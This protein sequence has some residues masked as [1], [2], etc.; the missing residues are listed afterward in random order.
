MNMDQRRSLFLAALLF[1]SPAYAAE[2]GPAPAE[3]DVLELNTGDHRNWIQLATAMPDP[4]YGSAEARSIAETVL[5]YQT[6]N[7][8]WAKNTGYQDESRIR[9]DEWERITATGIGATFDNDSTLTE[10]KFLAKVYGHV[11]DERYRAA[12]MRGFEYVLAAQYSN[13]G[14]PQYS[15]ARLRK[16]AYS[17]HITFNDDVMV[18][19]MTFLDDVIKE[20][21][22]YASIGLGE[23][24]K[25][26]AQEAFD[27]GLACILKTQIVVDGKLTVWCAQHD[28]ETLE[29]AWARS[30]EPPSFSGGESV[31]VVRF[32]MGIDQPSPE[33][34][35]AVEGAVEWLQA[36]AIRGW[37]IDRIRGEDGRTERRLV[38]DPE[39][40]LLWARFY[41]LGTN[42]PLYLDRDSKFLYDYNEVGHE[43]RSG[44]DYHG[45]WAA[46][47][48]EQGYPAWRARHKLPA[49]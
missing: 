13:G 2:P 14:W 29:P 10:M 1:A 21:P 18:N 22:L 16:S 49:R 28:F 30:Y 40:P 48:L 8:G 32:L 25:R 6:D 33:I 34:I 45:T 37:R 9:Q 11:K 39:A 12:F 7:G 46:G 27:K 47:L 31:G 5:K 35:A 38:A 4:W 17:A 24:M 15:P 42:R 19:V 23:E 26:R 41:E 43:R 44:Y 3:G 20:A 36:V